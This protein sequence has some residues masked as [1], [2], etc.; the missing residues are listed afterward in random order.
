[1]NTNYQL[2]LNHQRVVILGGTSGIGLAAAQMLLAVGAQVVIAGRD[3][4]KL[5]H[6]LA[7]LDEVTGEVVD[8]T[9]P[10][11]TAAFFRRVGPFDH[12][13]LT[14]GG[15]EG[16]GEFRTLDFAML[17]RVFEAKFWPQLI[18]AQTSLDYVRKD[19]SLT[20]VSAITAHTA[21]VGT[22]GLGAVNGA[23]EAIVPTLALELQP[24]RINAVAPGVIVT[25]WWRNLPAEAREELFAQTAATTPVKRIGHPEDVAQAITM[26][27]SNTFLT[28]TIIDCDGGA[29]LK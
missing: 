1:M 18:A 2:N 9:V 14:L 21:Y 12:L 24:L 26:L 11:E 3:R 5:A 27:I 16:L 19:G 8:A 7:T 6:A 28:G 29:R 4:D 17:R 10:E 23:L 15:N 25:P 22:A 13:V 20:I